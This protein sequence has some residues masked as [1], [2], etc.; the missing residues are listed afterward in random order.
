MRSKLWVDQGGT[1]TDC[2]AVEQGKLRLKKQLSHKLELPTGVDELRRGTTVATNAILE[3]QGE[4]VLLLTNRG[5]GELWAIGDQRRA[6]LFDPFARREQKLSPQVLEIEGRISA[7]GVVLEPATVDIE[8]L[9]A[10]FQ[11]GIRSVA[12]ALVHGPLAPEEELRVAQIVLKQ[13]FSQVSI[14]HQVT[15][16]R[17]FLARLHTTIADASLS[18]LLPKQPALYMCSDGGL[19]RH[20]S[21]EWSGAKAALSGPAGGAIAVE[22]L[23]RKLGIRQAFGFDMGGTSSDLCHYDRHI[24]RASELSVGGWQL[25]VPAVEIKTVAAGGGSILSCQEG[26]MKV[27]PRSV[28]SNP[29]PASYGRGGAA[30][31]TDAEVV[32]GRVVNFPNICGPHYD[33]PLNTRVA[34]AKLQQLLPE[35]SLEEIALQF[36]QVAAENMAGAIL[37]HAAEKGVDPKT[38]VLVA[39]GGA[40]PAHGCRVAE[41]LGVSMIVI[42]LLAGGFSALGIGRAAQRVERVV[43]F[44]EEVL[45]W[46]WISAVVAHL[47]HVSGKSQE[48]EAGAWRERVDLRGRYRGTGEGLW[49]E[50]LS[51]ESIAHVEHLFREA[52]KKR[53]GYEQDG[54]VEWVELR[55]ILEE[56]RQ[57]EDIKIAPLGRASEE[58]R[59]Y[60]GAWR[61]VPCVSWEHADGVQGPAIV[62]LQ[63]STVIVEEGWVVSLVDE[64]LKLVHQGCRSK[65]FVE[66]FHPAQTAIFG[67][68]IMALAEQMGERLARLARSASIRERRDF[69][70]AVFNAK[71][72]LIANAPHVP[73]HL[74]AMGETIQGL[75]KKQG[76]ELK[77]GSAWVSNDPYT[78]GS[79]LPD[80]TVMMPVYWEGCLVAFVANRGHHIDVGGTHPGSMPPFAKHI[81]E[82]G[83]LLSQELLFFNDFQPLDLSDSRQEDE[84]WADLKAQLSACIF[85]A[86]KLQELFAQ[87]GSRVCLGQFDALLFHGEQVAQRWIKANQGLYQAGEWLDSHTEDL[88]IAVELRISEGDSELWVQADPSLGNLNTPKA[89]LRAVLLYVMRALVDDD[90]PLNA[91][92]LRPW[93]LQTNKGG[94]CDPSYPR[95]VAA[96][97]VESSQRLVDA[98]MRALG[99]QAASQGTMNNVTIGT[100]RGALYETI[101]GGAGAGASCDGGSAVQVHMTNTRATDIEELEHRFPIRLLCWRRRWGSGGLGTFKG[102]DGVIKEWLF[103]E[104]ASV[105]LLAT[106]RKQPASGLF[107][108]L[109]GAV[110][111]DLRDCG[112]GWEPMPPSWQAGQGDRLRIE[113]PGGGGYGPKKTGVR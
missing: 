66:Y 44:A 110:G 53:L 4:A 40:G 71:G 63:G 102:G 97:N 23:C 29:G 99:V 90:I 100:R 28:G 12:V 17:G 33:Q 27:G 108:G 42:P 109:A 34:A 47:R 26:L 69:S 86:T 8:Q 74:G 1:F 81:E 73:V 61:S 62:L 104:P 22:H 6:D 59:A 14:G 58:T 75:L 95:A 31:L 68:R 103:L 19:A 67:R 93:K 18:P 50:A 96:G 57:I 30:S 91:G 5:F 54:E 98:I 106:R 77:E 13:G 79:H 46:D 51:G 89:V 76:A 65:H 78:G 43:P 32:L 16:S 36:Q 112:H 94:L 25:K 48:L 83:F 38:H 2:I 10:F 7:E 85:G 49:I 35:Y 3:Q 107:G 87:L 82:E 9:A 56:H 64:A 88:V 20:D 92:F 15:S 111:I 70:C 37:R 72:E 105:A 113:T 60:F 84:V 101:G 55:W 21:S 80:I 45:S 11:Q 52:H 39:F 41:Q 24:L